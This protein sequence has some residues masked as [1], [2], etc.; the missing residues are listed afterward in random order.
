MLDADDDQGTGR[1]GLYLKFPFHS[2]PLQEETGPSV[3]GKAMALTEELRGIL[4]VDRLGVDLSRLLR[5][6]EGLFSFCNSTRT[7]YT[8]VLQF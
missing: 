1:R 5:L 8:F 3:G 7:F 4:S 6:L 2:P